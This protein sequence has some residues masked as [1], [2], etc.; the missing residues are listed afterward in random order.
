MSEQFSQTVTLAGA[1]PITIDP[2][3]LTTGQTDLVIFDVEDSHF[4]DLYSLVS[5]GTGYTAA[6]AYGFS[7]TYFEI[8]VASDGAT[9]AYDWF[10]NPSSRP[11]VEYK[12]DA[13]TGTLSPV[14]PT[15][16]TETLSPEPPFEPATDLDTVVYNPDYLTPGDNTVT[17]FPPV[18]VTSYA[19]TVFLF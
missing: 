9:Y 5:N 12:L 7:S 4:Q 17:V 3:T 10:D 11:V 13:T 6:S 14:T 16:A 2:V 19:P 15:S 1:G 18:G 8:G